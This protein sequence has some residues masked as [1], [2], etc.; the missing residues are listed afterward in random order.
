[1]SRAVLAEG[2]AGR[3]TSGLNLVLTGCPLCG[4]DRGEPVAVGQDFAYRVAQDSFLVLSCSGCGL[5]Y[6]NPRP[7]AGE[8]PRLYPDEYFLPGER[9]WQTDQKPCQRAVMTLLRSCGAIKP[10]ARALEVSYGPALHLDL[11][12]HAG[13]PSWV[14]ADVVTPHSSL[15]RAAQDAGCHV[16][17][18][19]AEALEVCPA[20]Y[21][22][23]FLI[24]GLEHTD[25]PVEELALLRRLLRP[26]G[27]LVVITP[28]AESWAWRQFQGRHWAGYDFP[29]HS[30]LYSTQTLPKLAAAAGFAMDR[31]STSNHP[32]VWA[33]SAENFLTDW[34]APAWATTM[35]ARTFSLLSQVTALAGHLLRAD[36]AGAQLGA[37]LRKPA[38]SKV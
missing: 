23:I 31:V 13:L 18:S 26:G 21:D 2:P 34:A 9:T 5:L 33:R 8:R 16:Y 19:L 1:M 36:A 6:L 24:Y 20:G 11:V 35:V 25:A 3:V 27:R 12:R 29:R 14:A 38:E 17:E 28:N 7:A 4:E 37:V 30:C 22:F 10:D 15:A 32:G